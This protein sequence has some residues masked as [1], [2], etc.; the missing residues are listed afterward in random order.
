MITQEQINQIAE[1]PKAFLSRWKIASRY[2]DERIDAKLERVR[3]WRNR[4]ES[5]SIT[6]KH[7]GGMTPRGGYKESTIES[8]VCNIV[9]L[10]NEIK[11]ELTNLSNIQREVK[12]AINELIDDITKRTVLE[13]WYLND[14]SWREIAARMSFAE[15]WV[16]RLHESALKDIKEKATSSPLN[17]QF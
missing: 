9:D 13:F 17:T 11:E 16:K 1:D 7:D 2:A 5:I 14:F 10:E 6:L 4:A 3:E 12:A 15:R 8:A